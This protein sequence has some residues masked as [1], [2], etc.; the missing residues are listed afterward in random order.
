M[1]H[2]E[3]DTLVVETTGFTDESW[4]SKSGYFHGFDL[5]VTERLTRKGDT[6]LYQVTVED[7]EVL[8]RPWV[9]YPTTMR[10]NSDPGA[11]IE[12]ALPCEERD[13]QDMVNHNRGGGGSQ[14]DPGARQLFGMVIPSTVTK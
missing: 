6:I 4:L 1:G 7:P 11:Y 8:T 10:L 14:R 13:R 9:M 2:W 3:G 12:E 5:K